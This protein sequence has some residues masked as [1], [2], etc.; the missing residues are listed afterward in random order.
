MIAAMSAI[1]EWY[2]AITASFK[3]LEDE[4]PGKGTMCLHLPT[5]LYVL[6]GIAISSASLIL[7]SSWYARMRR[8]H[9]SPQA[10]RRRVSFD[11]T[12]FSVC[13]RGMMTISPFCL[14]VT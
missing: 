7:R 8:M 14:P 1:G 9:F 4:K 13:N 3:F 5:N 11:E 10:N 2:I 12:N 6:A